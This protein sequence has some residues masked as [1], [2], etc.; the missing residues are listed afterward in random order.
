MV[1]SQRERQTA[2]TAACGIINERSSWWE[3]NE[4]CTDT[5]TGKQ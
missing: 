2:D 4:K 5:H 3:S 1:S